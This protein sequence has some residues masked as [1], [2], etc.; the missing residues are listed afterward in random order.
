MKTKKFALLVGTLFLVGNLVLPALVA[1]QGED[2][3]G[4]LTIDDG[5]KEIYYNGYGSGSITGFDMVDSNGDTLTASSLQ[6][7]A[8]SAHSADIV[9]TWGEEEYLEAFIGVA[10]YTNTTTAWSLQAQVGDEFSGTANNIDLTDDNFKI[11]TSGTQ[12]GGSVTLTDNESD[13]YQF[14]QNDS[15]TDANDIY[16]YIDPSASYTYTD[17]DVEAN[18]NVS[19]ALNDA[20][21]YTVGIETNGDDILEKAGGTPT[22]GIFGIAVNYYHDLAGGTPADTYTTDVTY[23]LLDV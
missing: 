10:D 14:S 23:T 7:D 16:Y 4:T 12:W 18:Q 20:A 9:D 17:G 19:T 2:Q 22:P 1:A 15:G 11:A 3:E 8:F 21:T 6:Q 13:T 5:T